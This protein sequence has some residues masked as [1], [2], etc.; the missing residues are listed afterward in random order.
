MTSFLLNNISIIEIIYWLKWGTNN[1]RLPDRWRHVQFGCGSYR[2][3]HNNAFVK[4][5]ILV[6]RLHCGTPKPRFSSVGTSLDVSF[7]FFITCFISS[8]KNQQIIILLTSSNHNKTIILNH[9]DYQQKE[10]VTYH[11]KTMLFCYPARRAQYSINIHTCYH[12]CHVSKLIR[13]LATGKMSK[14]IKGGC[15]VMLLAQQI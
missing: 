15:I 1:T 11:K 2:W 14:N 8:R 4:R 12:T 3:L 7:W 9:F 10:D 13:K 5:G 6:T